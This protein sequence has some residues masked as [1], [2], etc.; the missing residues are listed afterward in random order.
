MGRVAWRKVLRDLQLAR[1]RSTLLVF[2]LALSLAAVGVVLS[3]YGILRREMP[4]SFR[5]SHP[6][7]ATLVVEHGVPPDVLA[8][9]RAR[10]EVEA[11]ELRALV[12]CRVRT[13][14]GREVPLALFVIADFDAMH[15]ETLERVDGAWPP[16]AGALLLDRSSLGVL[17]TE[18][19]GSLALTLPSGA[20]AD[21]G[22]AGVV[23]DAGVAPSA[24]EQ[25]GYGYVAP[26]TLAALG[27]PVVLDLL[28]L[29]VRDAGFDAAAIERGARATGA[30]LR[31]EGVQ[32][33][34]IRI[35]PPGQHPHQGLMD[36]LVLALL[37]FGVLA[38]VLCAL[39]VATTMS[40]LLARQ[41]HQIGTLKAIGA[42]SEQVAALYACQVALL[43][44]AAAALALAPSVLGAQALARFY[45]DGSNI[46]LASCAV[47]WWAWSAIVLAGVCAPLAASAPAVV[48]ASRMTVHAAIRETHLQ[49]GPA[50]RSRARRRAGVAAR[51]AAVCG[52]A[53]VLAWRHVW[54]RR[55]R[56]ALGLVLFAAGGS[57]FTSGVHVARAID[58]Q[59]AAGS[60]LP[61]YDLELALSAP[62]PAERVLALVRAV[63]AVAY[64]EP[65]GSAAVAPL[66]P[67]EIPVSRVHKDGGHGVKRIYALSP[68]TRFPP[69]VFAGRWLAEDDVD[70][71]AVAP[72]ELASLDTELGGD[73]T[74][75]LAGRETHW[76]VVGVVKGIGLGG[77][78]GLYVSNAGFARATGSE[79]TTQ[80]VR[81][82]G[83]E[84]GAAAQRATA[85]ELERALADAGI[86][87]ASVQTSAWWDL[88][89]RSHVTLVQGALQILGLVLGAVGAVTLASAL[90][91]SVVERTREFGVLAALG[92]TP[93]RIVWLV[94][95]EALLVGLASAP[96][97]VAGGIGLAQLLGTVFG[98][99][100]FG[101]PLALAVSPPAIA[102]WLAATLVASTAAA[103]LPARAAARLT[104]REALAHV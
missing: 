71:L 63:P 34:E 24:Q 23:R 6:A 36:A 33:D 72:G 62:Q 18:T 73:V 103:A 58:R 30:W 25:A 100:V 42:R 55:R 68:G 78:S 38:L 96:A 56:L 79:G 1:G 69:R 21:V 94:V 57:V 16:P 13:P 97:A 3:A 65:V 20:R 86:T 39:L 29:G 49:R 50:E 31:A 89:L 46:V 44:G 51:I 40:G 19:G 47:P 91:T 95:A 81:V 10:P 83:V 14:S 90:G 60:V 92:A 59:L 22:V 93:A 54:R 85:R 61:D 7:S 104:V 17:E 101:A 77:H 67:G 2:V 70:A 35:P 102:L 48:A 9:L 84:H 43:G 45:A 37:V 15:L 8:R 64:A 11:A 28:K 26:E 53:L 12:R 4:R 66:R 87:V 27:A 32:V 5:G 75:A 52:P 76:R 98:R 82:V 88:V 99:M 80:A 74:L 41:V